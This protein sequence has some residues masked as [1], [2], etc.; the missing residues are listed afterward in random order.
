MKKYLIVFAAFALGGCVHAE[1]QAGF[2]DEYA[3]YG[4]TALRWELSESRQEMERYTRDRNR[5]TRATGAAQGAQSVIVDLGGDLRYVDLQPT[6]D[7]GPPRWY[8][9]YHRERMQAH[10]RN[11]AILE[12]MTS[13]GCSG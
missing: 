10:A 9:K 2:L 5:G 4:C 11:Q 6:G 13:H 7:A 3:D 8:G 12:L 1:Y